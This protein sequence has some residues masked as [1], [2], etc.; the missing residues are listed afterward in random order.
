MFLLYDTDKKWRRDFP[1]CAEPSSMVCDTKVN[2]GSNVKGNKPFA[3]DEFAI[4]VVIVNL[5]SRK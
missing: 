2:R 4:K 1:E 3:G 5:N